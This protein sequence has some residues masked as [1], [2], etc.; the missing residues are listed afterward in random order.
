[1]CVC[2]CACACVCVCV[3]YPAL[4]LQ[5]RHAGRLDSE[6]R[7]AR[8]RRGRQVTL[9]FRIRDEETRVEVRARPDSSQMIRVG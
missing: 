7:P 4:T 6:R 2:A 3:R 5:G 1:M 8:A 9:T